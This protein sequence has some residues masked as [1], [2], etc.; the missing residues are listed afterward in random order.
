MHEASIESFFLQ[1]SKGIPSFP[2]EEE[3]PREAIT[4]AEIIDRIKLMCGLD[5]VRYKDEKEGSVV[6]RIC[7]KDY[8]VR[9]TFNDTATDQ[10]CRIQ[11]IKDQSITSKSS[12]SE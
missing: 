3:V 1:K 12:T 11:W 9:T 6:I 8:T 4:F 2:L 5:P 10:S 7:D